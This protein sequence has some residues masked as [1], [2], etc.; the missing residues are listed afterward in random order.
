MATLYCLVRPKKGSEARQRIEQQMRHYDVWQEDEVWQA[1]WRHRV[2]VLEG[3]VTLPLLGL[4]ERQ[5]EQLSHELDAILHSAAHVN[6]IYPYEALRATNVLGLHEI[7]RFAFQGKIKPVHHLST[8]AIWPMGSQITFYE[9]DSIEHNQLLNLGYD[10]AKWVGEQCLLNAA[11][12]GLPVV[13]YRPGEVGGDS[14]TGRCVTDHFL[15]ASIKGY[16]QFGAFP[17]LDIEVDIAP[18][19]YVAKALVYLMFER[20]PIGRAFHLTNPQRRH[21]SDALTFLRGQGY[22][23]AEQ[24]FELLRDQLLQSDNFASNALFAYQSVLEEMDGISLQLPI[25]DTRLTDR[26]LQ[27]SGISCPPADEKLFTTYVDYLRR[28][29]FLP[30]PVSTVSR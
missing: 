11:E 9:K 13:R 19:D 10:E 18:V 2:H 7:M 24:P 1:Q 14:V 15:F 29:G 30:E 16:L 26:F 27:G 22:Q 6:F 23:F 3:D 4:A 12:R 20:Q 8:A 21:M 17:T 5:Y 28:I 25:Y